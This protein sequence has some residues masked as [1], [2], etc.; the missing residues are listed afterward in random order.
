MCH[1][2][3]CI[4]V[5]VDSCTVGEKEWIEWMKGHGKKAIKGGNEKKKRL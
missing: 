5:R 1:K 4:H 2:N 3:A